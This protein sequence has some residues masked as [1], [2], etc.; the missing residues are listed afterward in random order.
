MAP[1]PAATH[2]ARPSIVVFDLDG[3]LADVRHRLHLVQGRRR[4]WDAFF[5][6]APRDPV[7]AEGVAA[8]RTAQAGGHAVAYLTGRPERCREDTLTWLAEHDL[9]P[10]ELFMRPERDRRPAR[11]TKVAALRRLARTHAVAAVV[12][13]DPAVI[14]AV[15]AAGF[16]V[17]HATWMGELS[18][19][20]SQSESVSESES[21][22]QTLFTIQEEEGRT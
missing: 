12:D 19:S 17:L 15:A 9:P 2:G 14:E 5:A 11:F 8:A 4:N 7:L 20:T 1:E 13:D 18:T 21:V 6:A 16:P 22:E 10:G 3:V